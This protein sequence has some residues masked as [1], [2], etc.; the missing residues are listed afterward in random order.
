MSQIKSLTLILFFFSFVFSTK[1][2]A[3]VDIR[4]EKIYTPSTVDRLPCICESDP[5]FSKVEKREFCEKKLKEF[6]LQHLRYPDM[7]RRSGLEGTVYVQF[8]VCLLYTSP[9]PR[10]QRG[11]RMP[12]S[13]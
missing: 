5:A 2:N 10:D 11:S 8:I 4:K 13:A 9:S 12:S 6:M 3:Q 7:A 1:I